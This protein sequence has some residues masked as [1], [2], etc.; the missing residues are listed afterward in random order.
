M[1]L[2]DLPLAGAIWAS[3]PKPLGAL[4]GGA[5]RGAITG[6]AIGL[7]A[8]GGPVTAAVGAAVGTALGTVAASASRLAENMDRLEGVTRRLVDQYKAYSPIIS[9]LRQQWILLDRR[10]NRIWANTLA[11]TL[12]K[13]TEIGTE[14]RERWTRMKV[15]FFQA[16][17]PSLKKIL[18]VIQRVSRATLWM[19]EKLSK[20]IIGVIDGLTKMHEWLL[21]LVPDW[22]KAEAQ[23]RGRTQALSP[24][25]M[26]W[27]TV[28]GPLT[29]AMRRAGL[30]TPPFTSEKA[31]HVLTEEEKAAAEEERTRE[32][33]RRAF[34][35]GLP[36][37][38]VPFFS[39]GGTKEKSGVS[40]SVNVGDSKELTAAFERVWHEATYALQKIEA[41]DMYSAFVLQG[42]GTYT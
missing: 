35:H 31:T 23:E 6:A 16:I 40:V 1:A 26:D 36:G 4:W 17:E 8:G 10:L 22:L 14:F 28:E 33:I 37:P 11:P 27:P 25:G 42:E 3:R 13:L 41:E 34:P 21:K 39:P 29:G 7:T 38:L 15:S 32:K 19:F 12:R 30:T 20:V 2:S 18:N 9:R 5:K 24:F